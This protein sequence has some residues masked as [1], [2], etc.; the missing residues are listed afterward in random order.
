MNFESIASFPYLNSIHTPTFYKNVITCWHEAHTLY[1][2]PTSINDI[3]NE[4][5]WGNRYIYCL[6][7][8]NWLNS[9]FIF[10]DDVCD[11][12]SFLTMKTIQ[13]RLNIKK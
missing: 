3:R 11:S 9:G 6:L 4:I 1:N 2:K 7:M 5:S 12:N 13:D 10:I 8:P